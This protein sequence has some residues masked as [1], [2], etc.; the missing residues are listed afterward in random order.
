[1]ENALRAAEEAGDEGAD[2]LP[3]PEVRNPATGH[4]VVSGTEGVGIERLRLE[5]VEKI[6]KEAPQDRLK[7][8]DNW[9]RE[10]LRFRS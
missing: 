4:L 9:H 7:L 3:I 1:M 10:R 6:S 8:P 2:E 5:I